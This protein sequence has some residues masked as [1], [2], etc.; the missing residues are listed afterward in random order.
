[1][2]LLA[3]TAAVATAAALDATLGFTTDIQQIRR[4][5]QFSARLHWLISR[6]GCRVNLYHL[7]DLEDKNAEFFCFEENSWN[8]RVFKM[9]NLLSTS[10]L[11]RTSSPFRGR[12]SFF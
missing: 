1:M 5:R 10:N 7:F 11:Y 4:D 3:T 8:Y 12:P 9:V 2:A 6:L